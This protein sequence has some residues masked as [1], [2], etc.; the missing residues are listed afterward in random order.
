[1]GQEQVLERKVFAAGQILMKEGDE[2]YHAYM[3][4]SGRVAVYTEKGG[5]RIDLA[6]LGPNSIVGEVALILDEPRGAS[7]EAI[8]TTNVVVIT[9]EEYLR[10]V[11]RADQTLK[12]ILSLVSQRLI[13]HN[14][15]HIQDVKGTKP[16]APTASKKQDESIDPDALAIMQGFSRNMKEERKLI[17]MEEVLPHMNGL[18]KAIKAMKEKG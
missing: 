15:T 9:R 5:Q 7:V 16:D 6:E 1:M 4:Q 13:M 12:S 3:I 17:M 11:E 18:I 10:K 2:G 8:E 14:E